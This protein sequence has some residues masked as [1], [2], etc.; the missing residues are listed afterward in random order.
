LPLVAISIVKASTFEVA[1][2]STVEFL[3]FTLFS[4]PAGVWVDRLRRRPILIL[5][6]WGRAFALAT[7]PL[8]YWLS[9]L[10]IWHL[11]AVGFV[12]GTLTVFFDIAYQSYLPS[13]VQRDQIPEGNAKLTASSSGASVGGPGLAGVLIAVTTAPFAVLLDALSFIASALFVTR[14]AQRENVRDATQEQRRSMWHDIREGLRYVLKHPYMRPALFFVAISNFFTTGL[15]ALMIVYGVRRLGLSAAQI[16]LSFSIGN[17]GWLVGALT[18]TRI[19]VRFGIGPTLVG[20]AALG[21]WGFLLIP[22]APASSMAIPF[23][24]TALFVFGIC[25][26]VTNIVAIS[27]SQAVT[28]DRLL[29]RM[30][31]SRRFAVFGVMPLGSLTA[32]ALGSSSGLHT[33][34]WICAVG[35]SVAFLPM[36]LSPVRSVRTL[37]DA[38]RNLGLT[39]EELAAPGV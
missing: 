35:A 21:G 34:I 3:P 25:A 1:A 22:L 9:A 37:K 32:G 20:A 26:V 15:F 31:A 12:V 27:L 11:Y 7:I 4:L 13:L 16:G 23:I 6:D 39:Q 19:S 10:T 33:A 14:I 24:S 36:V 30:T 18:A 2:L 5:C 17:V 38:E 28:P 8:A 29:G